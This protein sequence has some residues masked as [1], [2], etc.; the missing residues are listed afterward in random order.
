MPPR[1]AREAASSH[2][3]QR[4]NGDNL[5]AMAGEHM[6]AFLLVLAVDATVRQSLVVA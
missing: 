2:W 4:L 5:W 3:V 1:V 6:P